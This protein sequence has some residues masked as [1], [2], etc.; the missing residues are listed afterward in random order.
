MNIKKPIHMTTRERFVRVL[1][2][3]DADRVPYMKIFGG[4]NAVVPKW[5]IQFPNVESY[6]DELLGFEGKY[7]G[8][9]IAPVNTGLCGTPPDTVEYQSPSE[10]RI[11]HGD[12]SLTVHMHRGDHYFNHTVE[13][14]VKTRDDW[15]HI[16]EQW[17]DPEDLRRFPKDWENYI[18]LFNQRDYPLQLT[19]GGVFGF[20]RTMMGDEAMFYAIYDDSGLIHDIIGTYI[21]MC[22]IIWG[23]MVIDVPFDLIECWEDM[24]Y[25]SGPLISRRHFTEFLAPQYRRIRDFAGN[26]NIPLVLVDSDGNIMDLAGWM[27]DAGVNAMYPF[28]V[29]SGNDI[30][31]VRGRLTDM[32]CIGGLEKNCMAKGIDAMDSELEKA[33]MLIGQGRCIPGV[34]HFVL[35]DVPFENYVYFMRGLRDVIMKTK[36]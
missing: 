17:M 28:E 36:L 15:Q 34:D 2:G 8:W 24:A 10:T 27:R 18:Q 1:T 11:R 31:A 19:C 3:Q 13:Y 14:P 26:A 4:T 12:G 6:I 16:K 21:D 35:E 30:V 7:R 25:K 32:A 22:L 5:K 9:Q 29:Q 20:V 33:R 23:K